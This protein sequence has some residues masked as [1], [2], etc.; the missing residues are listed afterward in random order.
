MSGRGGRDNVLE[1]VAFY[2]GLV[3]SVLIVK[4]GG[5]L[6]CTGV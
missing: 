4:L 1:V 2:I 5:L 3:C 6:G